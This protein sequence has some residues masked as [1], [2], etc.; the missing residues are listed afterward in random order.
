MSAQTANQ[1]G[2][3]ALHASAPD[4]ARILLVDDNPD[5]LRLLIH[6]LRT[7]RL[8]TTV[9]FD[10]VQGYHRAVAS[11]P[12]LILLDVHMP[13]IN[14]FAACRLL[15]SDPATAAIPVVFLS[16]NASPRARLQGLQQGAV[17]FV[18][19]PFV[20][21]EVLA[22]TRIHLSL[23]HGR[24]AP[25]APPPAGATGDAHG[26]EALVQAA[27]RHMVRNLALPHTL[28][29][30][31]Q[32]VGVAEKR[33]ARALGQSRGQ[34]VSQFLR[35]ERLRVAVRLLSHTLLSIAEVAAEA[36]YSSSANFATAFLDQ[37]GMT[38]SDFRAGVLRAA[39]GAAA[40]AGAH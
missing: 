12:D 30:V 9:A 14:G 21:T 32:A 10:G 27:M 23:A 4:E 36:G 13:R 7:A 18:C 29:S 33:L 17:D 40:P 11:R 38:P 2:T 24:V 5:D 25:C 26:D 39:Q 34:S 1:G 37:M 35:E 20:P 6:I 15:K 22:R 3:P 16:A 31:A 8:H 19:K 28:R